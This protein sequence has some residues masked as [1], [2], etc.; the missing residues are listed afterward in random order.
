MHSEMMKGFGS[1][2]ESAHATVRE[3]VAVGSDLGVSA[4]QVALVWLR[5][6]SVPV[7][8]IIGARKLAQI[9]DNIRSLQ[10]TLS[11]EQLQ[12]LDKASAISLGFPHDFLAM[13]PVRAILYG[14]MRD[15]IKVWDEAAYS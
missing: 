5:Y 3:T 7:I 10:V 12:R 1:I 2:D 4:A 14:G 9:E 15:R 6:R 11:P 13:A 8:P